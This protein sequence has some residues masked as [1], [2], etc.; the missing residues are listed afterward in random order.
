MID[1][2]AS[3][4]ALGIDPLIVTYDPL[5]AGRRALKATAEHVP[6]DRRDRGFAR[7]LRETLARHEV[8]VLHAHGHVSAVYARADLPT[9]ATIHAALGSWRWLPAVVPALRRTDRLAAVSADLAT[10]TRRMTLRRVE[11]IPTGINTTKFFPG[12]GS[13]EA[14]FVIGIAARLHPVKRHVDLFAA[15]RLL[16]GRARL[17]IAGDGPLAAELRAAAPPNAEF[18]G[19]IA[20]MPAFYRSLDA[21]VLCSD[22]EGMPLALIEAMASGLP[23][24]A[25]RVGGM[26]DLIGDGTN[27]VTGVPRRDPQALTDALAALARDPGRRARD[28]AA[29]RA[30]SL[31]RSLGLQAAA[32]DR[33]YRGLA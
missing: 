21:F 13:A 10:S 26:I 23:C 5:P 31:G 2:C 29:A 14:E 9:V 16:G 24:V 11:V 4:P 22:H 20:D 3:A 27:G 17:R 7:R 30:A 33:L 8:A 1:L 15:L 12:A 6:L 25:T 19:A 18:L 32:Y 28:G